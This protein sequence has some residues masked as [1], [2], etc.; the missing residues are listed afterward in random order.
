MKNSTE[1][2]FFSI[3]NEN[4]LERWIS[5]GIT[6]FAILLGPPFL[7]SIVWYEKYGSDKKRTLLNRLVSKNCLNGISFLILTQIP[8]IIRYTYGPLPE[9]VCR[10]HLICKTT[11]IWIFWFNIDAIIFTRYFFII[12]LKNPSAFQDEFWAEFLSAW[13]YGTSLISLSTWH[14]LAKFET[15]GFYIC[16]GKNPIKARPNFPKAYGILETLSVFLHVAILLRIFVYNMKLELAN[17]SALDNI[18]IWIHSW[19]KK[20]SPFTCLLNLCITFV[21]ITTIMSLKKVETLPTEMLIQYPDYL[22][23]YYINILA[24][25]LFLS[26]IIASFFQRPSLRNA[27]TN[28]IKCFFH[29]HLKIYPS[30]VS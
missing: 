6:I 14:F 13:I 22:L 19:T 24:P 28:E 9:L 25:I 15:M 2:D 30:A 21:M 29:R 27:V 20:S 8:E 3:L 4:K 12:W 16:I 7:Y 11:H 23:F 1:E 18:N 26:A 5:L 10:V 17:K